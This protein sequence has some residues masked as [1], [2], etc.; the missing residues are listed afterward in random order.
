M[1]YT[2]LHFI[3]GSPIPG[4]PDHISASLGPIAER[5]KSETGCSGW[6]HEGMN[7]IQ[8]HIGDEPN[9]GPT[10][11][12]LF[13]GDRYI[14]IDVDATIARISLA[15]NRSKSEK[16]REM[17]R[18][19]DASQAKVEYERMS[20]SIDLA[21]ELR[22]RLKYNLRVADNKHSNRVFHIPTGVPNG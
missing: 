12:I 7:G 10:A 21:P 22:D 9:G 14:P 15:T 2:H 8:W 4:V 1:Q 19:K 16:D 11:D 13:Q 20:K 5:V 17:K 18:A 6:Y 3:D